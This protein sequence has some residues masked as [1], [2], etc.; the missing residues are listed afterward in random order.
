MTDGN[1]N[2]SYEG[3]NQV[4]IIHR[5]F[6]IVWGIKFVAILGL[7]WQNILNYCIVGLTSIDLEKVV[8]KS[9][10]LIESIKRFLFFNKKGQR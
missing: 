9:T 1:V 7:L 2:P 5:K 4:S 3:I 10:I 8:K 6:A